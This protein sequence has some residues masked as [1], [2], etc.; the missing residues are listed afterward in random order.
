MPGAAPRRGAAESWRETRG[1]RDG[2]TT[3]VGAAGAGLSAGRPAGRAADAP[4]REPRPRGGRLTCGPLTC[5]P[6]RAGG[7]QMGRAASGR[8]GRTPGAAAAARTRCPASRPRAR[9]APS[10]RPR[11]VMTLQGGRRPALRG[12]RH[13]RPRR[14]VTRRVAAPGFRGPGVASRGALAPGLPPEVPRTE[15]S[16]TSARGPRAGRAA[17]AGAS[18]DPQVDDRGGFGAFQAV[19]VENRD[20]SVLRITVGPATSPRRPSCAACTPGRLSGRN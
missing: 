20:R 4:A 8:L 7:G 3:P 9:P 13:V 2:T 5:G 12:P 6:A 1:P 18:G 14:H 17:P 16:R 11:D 10:P 19:A 15:D